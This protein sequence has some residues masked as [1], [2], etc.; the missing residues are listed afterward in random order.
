MYA[1][2][3]SHSWLATRKAYK[4]AL[5]ESRVE[6]LRA[7]IEEYRP[8]TV[9]FYGSN[10]EYRRY[11][12]KVAEDGFKEISLD[13]KKAY[14]LHRDGTDYLILGHPASRVTN[15][16]FEEAGRYNGG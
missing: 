11:W 4:K 13:S 9:V 1:D 10:A 7:L 16:Y 8:R 3:S 6:R 12:E 15:R 2:C 5:G 14:F